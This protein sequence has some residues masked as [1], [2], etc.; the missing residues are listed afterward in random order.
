MP[1]CKICQTPN[2]ADYYPTQKSSYCRTHFAERYFGP[3]RL[4]LLNAKLE[5]GQCEDCELKV[6]P[7][8]SVCFDW[9]HIRDKLRNVALMNSV[10]DA[11][12]FAEIAKCALVCSN[13]H[14]LRTL[15]RGWTGGRPR[16]VLQPTPL[17]S[18][19]E[20]SPR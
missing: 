2:P 12:F 9:D 20:S 18:G 15:K 17:V 4:R 13:C 10:S 3:G 1:T 8:T 11:V 16:R 6:T 5:R 7:E 14:R 19:P